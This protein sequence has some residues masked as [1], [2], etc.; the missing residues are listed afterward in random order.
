[1]YDGLDTEKV[2]ENK[3]QIA[4][5]RSHIEEDSDPKG[6]A[7]READ[8]RRE[9]LEQVRSQEASGAEYPQFRNDVRKAL[10]DFQEPEI[11]KIELDEIFEQQEYLRQTV[12]KVSFAIT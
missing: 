1:M 2:Q 6:T 8:I 11:D 9:Y 10:T 3:I 12:P 7:Q 5:F 4:K